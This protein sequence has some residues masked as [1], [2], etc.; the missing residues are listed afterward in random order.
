MSYRKRGKFTGTGH[1]LHEVKLFYFWNLRNLSEYKLI[2]P[3]KQTKKMYINFWEKTN[4]AAPSAT[5]RVIFKNFQESEVT[6]DIYG[7]V[8]IGDTENFISA[9]L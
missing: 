8:I 3:I 4:M 1:F 6:S 9:K 5:E 7:S 2:D